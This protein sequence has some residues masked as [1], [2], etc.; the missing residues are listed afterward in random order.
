MSIAAGPHEVVITVEGQ[1]TTGDVN[2][3]GQ[4]SILDLVLVARQLGETVPTNSDVDLNSDGIINILDLIIVAQHMGESTAAAAP[5]AIAIGDVVELNPAMIQAW[6]A[7]A[8]IEDDGSLAFQQG[9]RE[10]SQL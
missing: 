8:E 3:D 1:L 2:R 5:S 10:T 4:V 7:R 6:I 9:H